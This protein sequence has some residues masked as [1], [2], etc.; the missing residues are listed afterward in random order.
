MQRRIELSILL[1]NYWFEESVLPARIMYLGHTWQE[2]GSQRNTV[3]GW[4]LYFTVSVTCN[5]EAIRLYPALIL[6]IQDTI[7]NDM[8]G[9]MW[10]SFLTSG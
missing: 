6:L 3:C 1:Q 8:K 7:S 2:D 9:T 5:R 4:K 10:C